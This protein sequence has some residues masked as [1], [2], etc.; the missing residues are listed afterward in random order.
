[1]SSYNSR[2]EP[3]CTVAD[4][5][6]RWF[7][8][9]QEN[10]AS[11]QSFIEWQ[12]WLNAAPEH[13]VVYEQIEDTV[14]RLGRIPALPKLPS[15]EEMSQDTYAGSEPIAEWKASRNGAQPSRGANGARFAWSHFAIAAGLATT[16]L[17]SGLLW[18]GVVWH[19]GAYSYHTAPGERKV[20][21]LPEGSR[22]TL[23]ADSAL[24]V[25]L[26][27][28][29]RAVTL[30]QGEAYFEVAKN[31]LRPFVV[32][33][34]SALVTAVGTAFNVRRSDDRTVVAVTEGVVEFVGTPEN[35]PAPTEKRA[36]A[37]HAVVGARPQL[38]ARVSAGEG[39]SYLDDGSLQA[40]PPKEASLATG[41]L[42]GR[43]QYRN[44]PLRY[45]LA[46]LH[47]YTG[48]RFEFVTETAAALRFSGTLN[49]ND[50]DGWLR[51]LTVALPVTISAKGDNVLSIALIQ[52]P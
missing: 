33:A 15:A 7:L 42:S 31:R 38:A 6:A 52:P 45:V 21:D 3:P 12:Q 36:T 37:A 49:L 48:Q 20:I 16:V 26:S 23:G 14:L 47:R 29:R 24:A 32:R 30:R 10:T 13:R 25:N 5:A 28:G 19:Y 8:R 11:S 1:M 27:V 39:V 51:G 4:Q 44:E 17:F 40:L 22:V 9:L 35:A 46:D 34:G 50:T 18:L 43:R 2:W 41:W